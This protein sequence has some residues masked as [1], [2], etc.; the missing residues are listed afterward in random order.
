M[1]K[2]SEREALIQDYDKLKYSGAVQLK[3]A[4]MSAGKQSDYEAYISRAEKDP[5]FYTKVD[6]KP[7]FDFQ[8]AHNSY[9]SSRS[10]SG[11]LDQ[12]TLY[13]AYA[14]GID[15]LPNET[16]EMYKARKLGSGAGTAKTPTKSIGTFD[17]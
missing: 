11:G 5:S 10:T 8:K 12:Y 9:W 16:F 2:I 13:K 3:A 17:R 4:S 6:G 14:S 7:V 15:T 1:K